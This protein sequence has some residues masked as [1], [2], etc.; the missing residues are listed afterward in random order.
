MKVL[1]YNEL[2]QFLEIKGDAEVNIDGVHV[3]YG[4][5]EP[6]KLEAKSATVLFYANDE[7]LDELIDFIFDGVT[8]V[9]IKIT[10]KHAIIGDAQLFMTLDKENNKTGFKVCMNVK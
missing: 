8:Q 1:L 5:L 4:T 3:G 7:E 6:K 9:E 10:D 2:K